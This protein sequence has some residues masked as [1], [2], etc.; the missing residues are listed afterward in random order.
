[1]AALWGAPL[2]DRNASPDEADYE[3]EFFVSIAVARWGS[4]GE[5]PRP[6]PALNNDERVDGTRYCL[7]GGHCA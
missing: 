2:L 7:R 4:G 1:M 3:S 5:I 6:T